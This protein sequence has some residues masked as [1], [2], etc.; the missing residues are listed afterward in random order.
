[1]KQILFILLIFSVSFATQAVDELTKSY[2]EMSYEELK[3]VD[4]AALDKN[5]KKA[6]KK[7]LSKAK[8][9][10]RTR[11]KAE[12]KVLRAREKEAKAKLKAEK[13][14]MAIEAKKKLKARKAAQRRLNYINDVH[15]GT[16][17][18]KDEFEANIKIRGKSGTQSDYATISA[19]G[20]GGSLKYFIRGY[21]NPTTST[22]NFQLYVTVK[23]S[24]VVPQDAL[25]AF[26]V[27]PAAYASKKGWW[28]NYNRAAL[29]GGKSR[30]VHEID[31]YAK[32][33]AYYCNFYE[34]IAIVLD[35]KDIANSVENRANLRIKLSSRKTKSII[36]NIPYDYMLG[37]LLRLSET[38]SRLAS[39]GEILQPRLQEIRAITLE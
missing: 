36:I 37:Y 19:L 26:D 35:L 39:I 21:Y 1:M 11:I 10:E 22:G 4:K 23:F 31:Q 18:S 5:A 20:N 33:C 24:E 38:D 16:S 14:H 13:K 2:S 32:D 9:A 29:S 3:A 12:K 17:I 30:K 34:D 27:S 25:E 7:A 28:K 15:K 8:K 6:L